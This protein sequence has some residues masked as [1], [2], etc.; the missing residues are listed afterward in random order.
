MIVRQTNQD[1][2][3]YIGKF[4]SNVHEY[5]KIYQDILKS[6]PKS[7]EFE[8][9]VLAVGEKIV[10]ISLIQLVNIIFL[11]KLNGTYIV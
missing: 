1:D 5:S 7:N 9:F 6:I 2:L 11:E 4:L 3:I 10:G 8:S